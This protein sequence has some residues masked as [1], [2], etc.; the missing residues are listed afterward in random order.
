MYNLLVM[1][2][3]Y[4][5][6]REL[7]LQGCYLVVLFLVLLLSHL[8]LQSVVLNFNQSD[9]VTSCSVTVS[10]GYNGIFDIIRGNYA[11]MSPEEE[12]TFYKERDKGSVCINKFS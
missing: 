1:Y 11:L 7:Y 3:V 9:G 2:N 5:Y 4:L 10:T 12:T 6:S 8:V